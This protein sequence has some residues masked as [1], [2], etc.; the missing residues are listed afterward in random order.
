MECCWQPSGTASRN[1]IGIPEAF[2]L[3]MPESPDG[4]R[5]LEVKPSPC[6]IPLNLGITYDPRR[7]GV[8]VKE[9]RFRTADGGD[10]R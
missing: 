7:L 6:Y 2:Q 5:F 1:A 9:L 3:P 4:K 8:R 10:V